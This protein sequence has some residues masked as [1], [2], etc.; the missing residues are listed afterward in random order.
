MSGMADAAD[1]A[2]S[3]QC[4]FLVQQCQFCGKTQLDASACGCHMARARLIRS[5]LLAK[6]RRR[7]A[8][9]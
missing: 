9:S 8:K 1:L 4:G 5:Q 3:E 6:G 7:G 2:Y